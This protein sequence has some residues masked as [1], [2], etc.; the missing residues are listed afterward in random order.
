VL[1]VHP[2]APLFCGVDNADHGLNPGL[3]KVLMKNLADWVLTSPHE[4]VCVSK[5]IDAKFADSDQ[6]I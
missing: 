1:A 6:L 5:K 3:A 2:K 4:R